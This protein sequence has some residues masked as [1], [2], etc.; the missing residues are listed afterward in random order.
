MGNA[1]VERAGS[2][3]LAELAKRLHIPLTPTSPPGLVEANTLDPFIKS[4]KYALGWTYF[5]LVL[6]MAVT[7]TRCYHLWTD[8]LRQAI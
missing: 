7:V 2:Q 1:L 3:T 5:C 8:K 6:L 4:G